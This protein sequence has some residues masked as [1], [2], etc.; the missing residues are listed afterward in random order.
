MLRR[1]I[2]RQVVYSGN[3]IL[4]NTTH[5][6]V[7]E[8]YTINHFATGR[9]DQSGVDE[10]GQMAHRRRV[11]L[12]DTLNQENQT[13]CSLFSGRVVYPCIESPK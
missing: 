3:D 1:N 9:R 10:N 7:T 5:H 12:I 11:T 2:L 13:P 8:S 4:D 6:H